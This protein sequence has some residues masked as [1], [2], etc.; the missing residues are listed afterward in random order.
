MAHPASCGPYQPKKCYMKRY[1]GPLENKMAAKLG[2]TQFHVVLACLILNYINLIGLNLDEE[3][4]C[5]IFPV[6]RS[7]DFSSLYGA[8]RGVFYLNLHFILTF[9]IK[10]R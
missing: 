6:L 1:Y 4:S 8:K 2:L 9:G 3:T 10:S 7:S 5:A